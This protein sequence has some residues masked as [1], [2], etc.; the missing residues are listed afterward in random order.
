MT[1]LGPSLVSSDGRFTDSFDVDA[2]KAEFPVLSELV[3][4]KPLHYL[5]NA[6]TTQKPR[7]V[8]DTLRTYYEEY[9]ANIHRAVHTLSEKATERY[10]AGRGK[11]RTFLNA[12]SV[13]EIIFTRNATEG[14]NLV[15]Q[16]YGRK[17]FKPEDEILITA[18]EHHANIVPWQML[19]EQTG[20]VLKVVPIS[21]EGELDFDA[22]TQMLSTRTKFVSVTHMSNA[23]GTVNPI[24]KMIELAHSYGAPILIDAA[25]SAYHKKLDVQALDCDFLVFSG[26]KLYGPTGIGVLYGK[27][28]ILRTMPPYQ[29]GGDMILSVTF[30]KTIYNDLP[31]KFEAGTPHIAGVIGLGAAIDFLNDL[32]LERVERYE[33]ELLAYGTEALKAVPG[34]T[35]IG[36]APVKASIL[37]FV[38]DGVHP[39]DVGT[40]LDQ[41]GVAVRTGHH[42]AQPVMDRFCI[43]ATTR[44]SLA[45]YNTKAD[46]DALVFGLKKVAE[47]FG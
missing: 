35:I 20:A 21:D 34:L 40:L 42:C 15:A 31:Y 1:T 41:Y 9:N 13:K 11:V 27:E 30:E 14:V 45:C 38:M 3:H 12:A 8:I 36:T 47:V 28:E 16:T 29:G 2:V 18:M 33:A 7:I 25:Q 10:E 24:E 26:H 39:H 46:I 44:A 4:G 43:P 6:A 17:N 19:C 5:D 32:G 22:F 37:S 23:L